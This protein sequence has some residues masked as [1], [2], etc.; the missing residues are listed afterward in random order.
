MAFKICSLKKETKQIRLL[1]DHTSENF[2]RF[3]LSIILLDLKI[4]DYSDIPSHKYETWQWL[5]DN[6]VAQVRTNRQHA[7]TQKEMRL[8]NWTS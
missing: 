2:S 7:K 4:F 8:A 6:I 1:K 3:F 5:R